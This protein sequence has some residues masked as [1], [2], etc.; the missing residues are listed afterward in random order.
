MRMRITRLGSHILMLT[1]LPR[2]FPMNCFI[3]VEVDGLT[4]VDSTML[5][6]ADDV[7]RLA[8]ELGAP[9]RRLALTHAHGDH[10]GGVAGVR[11]RFPGRFG[12]LGRAPAALSISS[13]CDLGP[14]GGGGERSGP[15]GSPALAA[16]R[17][18]WSGAHR[19]GA[20]DGTRR[21][22]GTPP[23]GL[24]RAGSAHRPKRV[25]IMPATVEPLRRPWR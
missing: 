14:G 10:V 22:G 21:R 8:D 23:T 19:A 1:R 9:V 11:R 16:R 13:P 25:S 7:A 15:R 5:S 6:V 24:T 17:G 12:G 18:P 4:L 20:S 2:L 3:V